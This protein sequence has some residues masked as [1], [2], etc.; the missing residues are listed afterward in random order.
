MWRGSSLTWTSLILCGLTMGC[1]GFILMPKEGR[2]WTLNSAGYLLGPDAANGHRLLM[3]RPGL[4]GKRDIA[5]ARSNSDGADHR[6]AIQ[7]LVE[8]LS[9][10]RLAG[11]LALNN[12]DHALTEQT[13]DA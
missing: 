7:P 3:D 12:L 5:G 13:Q 11:I 1:F 9:Y 10:S 2:G 8:M 4:A 6:D